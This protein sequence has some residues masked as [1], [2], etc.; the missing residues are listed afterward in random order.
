V[1]HVSATRNPAPSAV[2]A[3]AAP[4]AAA[5][6]APPA[7]VRR[8]DLLVPLR[9]FGVRVSNDWLPRVAWS[10][11]RTGRP[12]LIGLALL[13]A[14]ALFFFSTHLKVAE[15]AG[16]LRA[17]LATARARAAAAPLVAVSDPARTLRDLPRRA[18]MPALLGLLL[19]QADAA[20]LTIDTGKYEMNSTRTGAVVRYVVS[21]PVTGPYPKL[22]QFLDAT[23]K[24]MPAVAISELSFE[25]KTIA[26]GAVAAQI[27]LTVFTRSA[28]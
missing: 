23:L 16:A 6:R 13:L 26:D 19:Q 28:S 10:V 14:S 8:S 25:R 4:V 3:P 7:I 11:S 12:G 9:R 15:Q 24:A 20:G 27:R 22:R 18:E 2:L 1:A 5:P 17:E 21:F